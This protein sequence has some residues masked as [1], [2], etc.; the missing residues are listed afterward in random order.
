M[1]YPTLLSGSQTQEGLCE[2]VGWKV[3]LKQNRTI[4]ET[5]EHK[6]W[7][8]PRTRMNCL[9]LFNTPAWHSPNMEPSESEEPKQSKTRSIQ[10]LAFRAPRAGPSESATCH[11]GQ[12][13]I[14][15]PNNP[16]D[17]MHEITES[18]TRCAPSLMMVSGIFIPP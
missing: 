3:L 11:P 13:N 15:R 5:H 18:P 14:V 17:S 16:K 6:T 4:R 12:K 2:M 1:D 10:R 8:H 9:N 7:S